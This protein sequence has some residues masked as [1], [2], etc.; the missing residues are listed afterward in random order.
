MNNAQFST[1][2]DGQIP[3]MKMYDPPSISHIPFLGTLGLTIAIHHWTI[4]S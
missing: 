3:T 2:P 1:P 4:T